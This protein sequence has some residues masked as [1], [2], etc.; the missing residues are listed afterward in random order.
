MIHS[1]PHPHTGFLL[2]PIHTHRSLPA[3]YMQESFCPIHTGV[4]SSYTQESSCLIHAGVL[5]DTCKSPSQCMYTQGVLHPIAGVLLPH[6]HGSSFLIHTG[7]LPHTHTHRSLSAPYTQGLCPV[8][9]GVLPLTRRSYIPYTKESCP[10]HKGILS[11][12]HRS[13]VL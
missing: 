5:P 11:H 9:K 6:T 12:T 10:I 7:V 13:P 2:A 4:L 8:H 3:S 1:C